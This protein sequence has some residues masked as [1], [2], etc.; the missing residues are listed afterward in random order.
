MKVSALPFAIVLGLSV[1]ALPALAQSTD[2]HSHAPEDPK[3]SVDHSKMDHSKMDHSKMD[4]SKMDHSQ[5]DQSKMDHSKMDH[6]KMDHSK[7]DHSKMDHSKM[8]HSG[9]V[10]RTP[11]PVLTDAD[12][13]AAFPAVHTHHL[14]GT[15]VYNYFL[16]DRLEVNRDGEL[17]WE[18]SG[19]IGG[20]IQKFAIQSEGHRSDGKISNA[21]V[22]LLYSRGIR[23]W[24]DVVGGI[25]KDFGEGA[26]RTWA[27]VGVQGLAPYKFEVSAM[28]YF[29]GGGRMMTT[30]EGEYESVINGRTYLQWRGEAV[31]RSKAEPMELVGSGLNS[32]SV[33]VRLRYE[34]HRQF[35][36]YVGVEH[37][38]LFGETARLH[39][40]AGESRSHTSVLAGVRIWF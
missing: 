21:N 36:P 39:R 18:A 33:G 22:D 5:M 14:H 11:I 2:A 27:A 17:A 19:W 30:R 26:D 29:S 35:A 3:V 25:R 7:M 8:D 12:R 24:W 10:L 40:G 23:D 37:E 38:R 4:H 15:G 32:A 34:I 28:T 20:D 1:Q 13:L 31:G 6:S 9:G 16:L